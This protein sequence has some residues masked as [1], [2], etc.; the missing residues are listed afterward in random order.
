VK[1]IIRVKQAVIN[2]PFELE[3][4]KDIVIEDGVIID[5]CDAKMMKHDNHDL[6]DFSDYI[7]TPSFI[8]THVHLC[9]TL[10]RGLADNMELLDWLK[11]YIFPLE[12]FHDDK[13]MSASAKIGICEL[14]R[15]GTTTIMDMGTIYHENVIIDEVEKSGMRAFLG[16]AMMDINDLYPKLK[17]TTK[18]SLES[19]YKLAKEIANKKN[20]KINYAFTP[21]FI[22][23]CTDKLLLDAYEIHKEFKSLYHIHASENR[24]EMEA[25]YQR[26]RKRNIEAFY[27]MGLLGETSCFAHCI[28]LDENEIDMIAKTNSKVLH[29][30][31]SNF[32]LK[33]GMADTPKYLNKGICVSLGSDGAPCNNNLSQLVEMRQAAFVQRIKSPIFIPAT[34]TFEIATINGAKTL[35]KE[36]EIGSIEIGKKADILFWDLDKVWNPLIKEDI[37]S[38]LSAIVYSSSAENINSVMIDGKFVIKNRENLLY[39]ETELFR[40]GKHELKKSIERAGL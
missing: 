19:S 2:H 30:P 35:H 1:T 39:D 36:N 11:K 3:D 34:T 10:F 4:N 22:L 38:L 23:S 6:L 14:I 25:V 31:S 15:T 21:R 16:K 32:K 12:Y 8:Q 7:A 40:N 37:E 27:D 13:S 33:S 17:E 18:D 24:G 20:T 29:C 28:W 26:T 9:Q 5:I